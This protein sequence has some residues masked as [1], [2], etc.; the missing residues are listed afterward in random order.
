MKD[1]ELELAIFCSQVRFPMVG[2]ACIS[3]SCWSSRSPAHLRLGIGQRVALRKLT[4][5]SHY[6]AHHNS[7]LKVER[8]EIELVTS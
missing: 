4:T 3:L 5:E 6:V 7:S 1:T 8:S 2:L